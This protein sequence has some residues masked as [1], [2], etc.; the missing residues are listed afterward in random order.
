M[1]KTACLPPL[2]L[3]LEVQS[4]CNHVFVDEN[5]SPASLRRFSARPVWHEQLMTTS[6][7]CC[8]LTRKDKRLFLPTDA[9]QSL[10]PCCAYRRLLFSIDYDAQVQHSRFHTS[11]ARQFP[12]TVAAVWGKHFPSSSSHIRVFKRKTQV[13]PIYLPPT[14]AFLPKLRQLPHLQQRLTGALDS[15]LSV[16]K[17]FLFA[18]KTTVHSVSATMLSSS[19]GK[20]CCLLHHPDCAWFE[21]AYKIYFCVWKQSLPAESQSQSG[22]FK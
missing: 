14:M 3:N 12:S 10:W 21:A 22:L 6:A 2:K 1:L 4:A 5:M 11:A 18:W 17:H 15:H 8:C 13:L 9:C 7:Y 19:S 16:T 20:G